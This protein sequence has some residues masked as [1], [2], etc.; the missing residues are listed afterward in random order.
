MNKDVLEK[1][2]LYKKELAAKMFGI[3]SQQISKP[4]AQ[5]TMSFVPPGN[6]VVGFGYGAKITGVSEIQTELAVRVYVKTKLTRSS[7]G[8]KDIVPSSI[9]G[10]PTDV[11]PVGDIAILARPIPCGVSIGHFQVTAGTLGC[12]VKK[13][14]SPTQDEEKTYILSNNHVLANSNQ[15]EIGDK[16]L[17]PGILDGGNN[18]NPIAILSEFETISFEDTVNIIDAA[19]AEVLNPGDV[20]PEIS[21]IGNIEKS[22]M[23]PNLY[24]SVRKRGRTTLHTVGVIMD[25]SADIRVRYGIQTA[26]FENQ[27]AINGVGSAFSAGGDSG[28]LIVDAV[29][30]DPVGLLFAGG[31][32]NNITF[33]NPIEEVL[34]HFK[35]QIIS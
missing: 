27:I 19:I 11:I 20:L 32:V 33:A 25:I 8:K 7:L 30:K 16:I 15:A 3:S 31:G 23:L 29:T 26:D 9:N 5:T 6:N 13:N 24:Q 12:L 34:S 10:I 35:V 2:H 21:E 1:A 14:N 28:S 17:E 4:E 22:A 18:D